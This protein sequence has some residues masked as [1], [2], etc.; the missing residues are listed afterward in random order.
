MDDATEANMDELGNIGTCLLTTLLAR[1]STRTGMYE[2]A[3]EPNG[4]EPPTNEEKLKEFAGFLHAELMDRINAQQRA[5]G[6]H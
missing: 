1:V 5:Q 2:K 6:P 4:G 3:E